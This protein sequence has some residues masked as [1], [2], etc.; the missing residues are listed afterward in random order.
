MVVVVIVALEAILAHRASDGR[1]DHDGCCCK[2]EKERM[3]CSGRPV[4]YILRR[5]HLACIFRIQFRGLIVVERLHHLSWRQDP[6]TQE[7]FKHAT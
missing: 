7:K 3:F 5:D 4:L 2:K 1:V 6:F